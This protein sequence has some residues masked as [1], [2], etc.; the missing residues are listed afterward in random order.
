MSL[1]QHLPSTTINGEDM[2][3]SLTNIE[4]Q[5]DGVNKYSIF[6]LFVDNLSEN[7]ISSSKLICFNSRYRDLGVVEL[8]D[9]STSPW[10]IHQVTLG[11]TQPISLLD[12][13]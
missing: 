8:A 3:L 13:M 7:G 5:N 4:S 6:H 9:Y 12:V 11:D 2:L 1:L 10:R